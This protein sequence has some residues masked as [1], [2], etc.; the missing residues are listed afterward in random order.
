MPYPAGVNFSRLEMFFEGKGKVFSNILWHTTLATFPGTWD[1]AAAAV[2]F[3]TAYANPLI[4]VL[5]AQI[6]YLGCN[7]LVHNAGVARSSDHYESTPGSIATGDPLPDDVAAVV[8]RL[9]TT[10]GKSGRGRV[11]ISGLDPSYVTENRLSSG[12]MTN[13]T[14]VATA[15]KAAITDQTMLWSPANYSRKTSAFHAATNFVVDPVTGTRRD[16]RTRR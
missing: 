1:I 12:G 6:D 15:W 5:S 10:A 2:A 16:R 8:S 7:F 13:L 3:S 4:S 9:T 11:Y 14:T